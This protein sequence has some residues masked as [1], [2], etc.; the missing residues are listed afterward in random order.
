MQ[1]KPT[2]HRQMSASTLTGQEWVCQA[3]GAKTEP[4]NAANINYCTIKES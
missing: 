4:K 3:S 2:C 1:M